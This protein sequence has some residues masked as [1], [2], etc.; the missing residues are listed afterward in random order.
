MT[1]R[2]LLARNRHGRLRLWADVSGV[3]N[4][5]ANGSLDTS[6]GK[7]LHHERLRTCLAG[8]VPTV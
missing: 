7:E 5:N 3:G 1:R 2:A 4:G 8:G 6:F